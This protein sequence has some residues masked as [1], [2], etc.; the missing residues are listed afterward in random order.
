MNRK[1][2]REFLVLNLLLFTSFNSFTQV[3]THTLNK[4]SPDKIKIDGI[5]TEQEI[6]E[7]AKLDEAQARLERLKNRSEPPPDVFD[8]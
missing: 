8:L 2:L 6:E 1:S 5:I 3:R 4:I 7:S